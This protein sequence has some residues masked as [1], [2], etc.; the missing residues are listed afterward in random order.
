LPSLI[1]GAY[2]APQGLTTGEGRIHFF[3]LGMSNHFFF[4]VLI[5]GWICQRPWSTVLRSR[6]KILWLDLVRFCI[7]Y[8]AGPKTSSLQFFLWLID[9]R[10]VGTLRGYLAPIVSM[11]PFLATSDIFRSP[12][13]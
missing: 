1:S 10:T 2:A 3:P 12:E 7:L 4:E 8:P 6:R 5:V 11:P 13:T 9:T